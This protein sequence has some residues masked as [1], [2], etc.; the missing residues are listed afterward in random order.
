M[1]TQTDSVQIED[2]TQGPE[3]IQEMSPDSVKSEQTTHE[4][5]KTKEVPASSPLEC[6]ICYEESDEPVSTMCGHIYCWSC[7]YKW[8]RTKSGTDNCPVCKNKVSEDKLIPLYPKNYIQEKRNADTTDGVPKRPHAKRD[9]R[10]STSHRGF[11]PFT[12]IHLNMPNFAVTIGCLPTLLP[13]LIMI[14]LNCFAFFFDDDEDYTRDSDTS[15]NYNDYEVLRR[16][17]SDHLNDNYETD[18][19]DWTVILLM[20]AFISLPFILSRFRR[21]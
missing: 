15:D 20:I 19:F 12:G 7:I 6:N 3:N 14:V 2:V 18:V 1:N 21:R 5:P 8:V 4:V 17:S 11:G 10:N 13:M 9:E 16:S